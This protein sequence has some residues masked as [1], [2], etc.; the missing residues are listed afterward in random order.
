MEERIYNLKN[1]KI[2]WLKS[3]V[4]GGFLIG[5]VSCDRDN[6]HPG[7]VYFPDMDESEAYE[8]YSE[9]PV[10]EEGYTNRPP[11]E[12]TV[13]RGHIPYPYEKTDADMKKAGEELS[14]PYEPTQAIVEAGKIHYERFC[15][16]CHGEYGD[17]KGYLYTSGRYPYPPASLITEQ[18]KAKPEGETFHNITVGFGVMGA[19]GP[20]VLPDD[21]WKIVTYITE[22]LYNQPVPADTSKTSGS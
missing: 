17:G 16:Q 9:N 4:L 12:G 3:I 11:V 14:N 5:M 18:V 22:V 15:L 2:N 10:F 7:Y 19:H 8:T 13:P 20:L 21:R 6:N 1:N